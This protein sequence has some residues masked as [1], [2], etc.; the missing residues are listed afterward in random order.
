MTITYLKFM[1]KWLAKYQG[2][3]LGVGDTLSEALGQALE[4]ITRK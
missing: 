2:R 1:G 3:A 4:V